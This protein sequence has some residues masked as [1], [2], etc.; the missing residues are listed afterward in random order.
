MLCWLHLPQ[1]GLHGPLF[2]H[3]NEWWY[4]TTIKAF[5][6]LFMADGKA[7][8]HVLTKNEE[9]ILWKAERAFGMDIKGESQ[10]SY[11]ILIKMISKQFFLK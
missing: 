3:M 2:N 11:F 8:A 5:N 1:N 4:K 6:S 9:T 7:A 10:E